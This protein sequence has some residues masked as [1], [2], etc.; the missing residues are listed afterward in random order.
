MNLT[1]EQT[2]AIESTAPSILLAAC[3]G[4]GKTTV[5]VERVKHLIASGVPP[6]RI[7]L[8]TFTNAGANE[9]KK[10]LGDL[11]RRL[12]SVSTLH[13]LCLRLLQRHGALVGLPSRV[14][15][16]DADAAAALLEE[17]RERLRVTC[18]GITLENAVI[19]ARVM[20]VK[21]PT[22]S[23]TVGLE[24]M[25]VQR[26]TGELDYDNIL[27]YGQYLIEEHRDAV[28][29]WDHTI[30]DEAQ[31]NSI[32]DWDI[33]TAIKCDNF[34]A[35]GDVDQSLFAFRGAC[36]QRFVDRSKRMDTTL[37]KLSVNHRSG[38]EIVAASQRLI[39]KNAN[40]IPNPTRAR[41]DAPESSIE[42]KEHETAGNELSWIA[43][44]ILARVGTVES[45]AVLFRNNKDAAQA[46]A[47]FTALGIKCASKPVA[48]QDQ[49]PD[50]AAGRAAL[51]FL[52]SP[53]SER[54]A[55]RLLNAQGFDSKH[56]VKE[57][58]KQMKTV[59]SGFNQDLDN[60]DGEWDIAS[61][62]Q[63]LQRLVCLRTDAPRRWLYDVACG[64]D[65]TFTLADLVAA[66]QE[67][68]P[69]N[70]E[71]VTDGVHVGTVHSFKGREA[72]VVF[73]AGA[74]AE[75]FEG[76]RDADTEAERRLFFVGVTR[77]R[78][79]LVISH[80]R[81]RTVQYNPKMP[82][83]TVARTPSRFIQETML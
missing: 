65:D 24:F 73:L 59:A 78:H 3:P 42:V 32:G 63:F 10:R 47:H 75:F 26:E 53:D 28:V 72:D 70:A 15:V 7:C 66:A 80:C 21:N 37:L 12:F 49:N 68:D 4:S 31:D 45:V 82:V 81:T 40:R 18:S 62:E 20:G 43:N 61:F 17:T 58:M 34:F 19:A 11:A 16:L 76:N 44:R 56:A 23:E 9:M 74:E 22:P 41:D 35:C 51:A 5:I 60:L 39:T 48:A 69:D 57:R 64:C 25:R 1:Q 27:L 13:S 6:E 79:Q 29:T 52:A 14:S 38:H 67:V 36:P 83:V 71:T 8:V 2:E 33:L 30:C 55:C 50:S 46:R 77:A 54:A